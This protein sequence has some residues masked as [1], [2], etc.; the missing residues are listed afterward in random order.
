MNLISRLA[1]LGAVFCAAAPFAF[2]QDVSKVSLRFV[3]FPKSVE[4]LKVELLIGE[5]K[6]EELEVFSNELSKTYSVP[7]Q[8]AWVIG[9]T[10]LNEDDEPVFK[11]LGKATALSASKQLVLIVKKGADN[12]DGFEMV[13]IEDGANGFGGGEMLFVNAAGVR[14]GGVVGTRKFA[15][16][17]GEH[18]IVEPKADKGNGRLCHASLFYEQEE[19]P[20]PFFSS[21]WPVSEYTRAMLFVYHD[22][23]SRKLRLHS[24][25]D[26]LE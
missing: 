10:T 2:S 12:S 9:E 24:I 4:P 6:T 26:Y 18:A 5:G 11:V 8:S 17:P 22:P 1:V 19:K 13:A 20:V 3:C 16:R 15:L 14:I 23:S 7:A 25:R 21:T